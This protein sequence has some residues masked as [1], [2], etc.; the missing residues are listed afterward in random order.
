[1]LTVASNTWAAQPGPRK[2]SHREFFIG[3]WIVQGEGVDFGGKAFKLNGRYSIERALDGAWLTTS[4][5]FA[6]VKLR[7]YWGYDVATGC[8]CASGFRA[9]ARFRF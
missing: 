3:D 9:A 2:I 7:E 5:D 8:F 6:G 4:G 1:M